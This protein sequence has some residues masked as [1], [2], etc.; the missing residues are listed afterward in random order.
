MLLWFC[1]IPSD[2]PRRDHTLLLLF[3]HMMIDFWVCDHLASG[4][5]NQSI[6]THIYLKAMF[7]F[8]Y[9]NFLV[10]SAQSFSIVRP[11]NCI[12]NNRYPFLP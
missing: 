1:R 2:L 11:L 3:H 9:T 6:S 4:S 8:T 5:Q 10:L 7:Y 12:P